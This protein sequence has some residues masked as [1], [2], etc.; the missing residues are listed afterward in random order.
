M[1][2]VKNELNKNEIRTEE[3]E[4]TSEMN[5]IEEVQ[6]TE[7][8]KT[9]ASADKSEE[10]YEPQESDLKSIEEEISERE[11]E[12]K[13]LKEQKKAE[14]KEKFNLALEMS[15]QL[16]LGS[17][18]DLFEHYDSHK[19]LKSFARGAV[20][21]HIKFMNSQMRT[22]RDRLKILEAS[23]KMLYRKYTDVDRN[24]SMLDIFDSSLY[25]SWSAYTE[26]LVAEQ[27]VAVEKKLIE[28][29][30]S[31]RKTLAKIYDILVK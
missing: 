14:E 10:D 28:M 18:A 5:N 7:T 20:Y 29:T 19:G 13:K 6:D 21:M 26:Y 12:E 22:S 4:E 27:A 15:K 31:D 3:P 9:E 30:A 1:N 2:E 16:K 23:K 25:E 17:N 24:R 11:A 8:F